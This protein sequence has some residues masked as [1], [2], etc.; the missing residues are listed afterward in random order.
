MNSPHASER[1]GFLQ[2]TAGVVSPDHGRRGHLLTSVVA[3]HEAGAR[4]HFRAAALSAIGRIPD[5]ARI[6]GD[7]FADQREPITT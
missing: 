5:I 6:E 4:D 7:H 1:S 2:R 3:L